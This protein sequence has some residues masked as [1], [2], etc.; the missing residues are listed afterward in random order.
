LLMGVGELAVAV[1]EK[2]KND[3]ILSNTLYE[4]DA[5]YK[6]FSSHMFDFWCNLAKVGNPTKLMI[7]RSVIYKYDMLKKIIEMCNSFNK[8]FELNKG[9]IIIKTKCRKR[10]FYLLEQIDEPVMYLKVIRLGRW[11]FG[12]EICL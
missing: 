8:I 6:F 12:F 7:T 1:I 9:N 3:L 10:V 4:L 2:A 11:R 5:N